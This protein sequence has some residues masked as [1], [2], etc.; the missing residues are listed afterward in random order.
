MSRPDRLPEIAPIFK[1]ELGHLHGESSL[2]FYF[3]PP[4]ARVIIEKGW[5]GRHRLSK[6]QPWWLGGIKAM[7][8]IGNSFLIVYAPRDAD[9]LDVLKTLIKASA[10]WMT[11]QQQIVK[12]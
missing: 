1:G 3:S 9:E 7:W 8:G 4:D 2:H 10:V 5:A 11:G 6:T 12:P